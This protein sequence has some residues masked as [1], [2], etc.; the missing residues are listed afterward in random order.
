[1]RKLIKGHD[2]YVVS[3]F[4]IITTYTLYKIFFVVSENDGFYK[5]WFSEPSDSK[6]AC[7]ILSGSI[8][9]W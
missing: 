7:K 4:G 6:R 2:S 9:R 1:M 8:L 3:T 5:W